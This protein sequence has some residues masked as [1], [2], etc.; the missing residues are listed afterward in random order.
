MVLCHCMLAGVVFVL[1]PHKV[2]TSKHLTTEQ[3][4]TNPGKPTIKV[5]FGY[6]NM[7]VIYSTLS[8]YVKMN[9]T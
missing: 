1:E 3:M 4:N 9:Y 2:E 7:I 6:K 8:D 5:L